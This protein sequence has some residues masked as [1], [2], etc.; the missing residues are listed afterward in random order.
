MGL[1]FEGEPL[2]LLLVGLN[3]V[4]PPL[5]WTSPAT[6]EAA[7]GSD[8]AEG[9]YI[10]NLWFCGPA[11]LLPEESRSVPCDPGRLCSFNFSHQYPAGNCTTH[12]V[13]WHELLPTTKIG[14]SSRSVFVQVPLESVALRMPAFLP[15]DLPILFDARIHPSSSLTGP[16][17]V[18]FD[19]GDNSTVAGGSLLV[20]HSFTLPEIYNVSVTVS[21]TISSMSTFVLV[22]VEELLSPAGI[23]Q[24]SNSTDVRRDVLFSCTYARGS[25][26]RFDWNFGDGIFVLE[27][28]QDAI[29][30][31][32]QHSGVFNVTV[33][34]FN[35]LSA[36]S[37]QSR[38]EIKTVSPS[39]AKT[40]AITVPI[41]LAVVSAVLVVA[42]IRCVCASQGWP[43]AKCVFF[44]LF[45]HTHKQWRP[46]A[47]VIY[48]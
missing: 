13:V 2:C 20:E 33:R 48:V 16:L 27:T 28:Y 31:R 19:F 36:S 37:A 1:C 18:V 32:Y 6:L 21:N 9:N 11:V 25:N 35:D 4:L 38:V 26:V 3:V 29:W 23:V 24:T 15:L 7:F 45:S 22:T 14:E 40:V 42:T 43:A 10:L 30:H 12:L 47:W 41:L 8:L 5:P 39:S 17:L 34:A 46:Q 44:S